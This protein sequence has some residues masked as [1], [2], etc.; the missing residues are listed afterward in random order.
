MS[1]IDSLKQR[2]TTKHIQRALWKDPYDIDSL[3]Q[4]AS[5]LGTLPEPDLDQK[6]KILHRILY[7]EPAH[8]T[9][10]Q[11]LLDIDRA[12]IGGDPSRLHLAV[13]LTDRLSN[14]PP[15]APLT[16]KYSIVHQVLVYLFVACTTLALLYF[17]REGVFFAV[18]MIF[19]LIPVWFIS[20]V[21]EISDVG[22]TISRLF[23]IIRSKILWHE[24]EGVKPVAI[25]R[26]IR[27]IHGKGNAVAISAQI[28]GYP[29]IFD[30]LQQMRPDL[31]P[32]TEIAWTGDLAQND[33][34]GA[35]RASK[36]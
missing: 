9:A 2:K 4:L 21:V 17:V 20:I 27:I 35:P 24:I 19:L 12:Q 29:F 15:E 1:I 7:L 13:I 8:K 23:G 16:L 26:G 6:R 30:I 36:T 34:P 25:G 33:S 22:L 5:M 31:L 10:R 14:N 32:L 11:M 3:L 28:N 18:G